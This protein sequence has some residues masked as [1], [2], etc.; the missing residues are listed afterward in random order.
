MIPSLHGHP[1]PSLQ[2][3]G[4]L[5]EEGPDY[6]RTAKGGIELSSSDVWQATAPGGSFT[7]YVDVVVDPASNTSLEGL[8]MSDGAFCTQ[9]EAEGFRKITFY[10]D[11]PDVMA[12]F[13]VTVVAAK[14]G[15]PVLLSN[16]NLVSQQELPGG[17]HE[18]VWEDPFRKPC[19]LFALVAGDLACLED[20]FKTV[21]GR[22]VSLKILVQPHN[23]DKTH[24]AL[25]SLKAAMAWDEKAFG[26]EY[27]LDVFHIV[28]VDNFNMARARAREWPL[29][30]RDPAPFF[31]FFFK[32]PAPISHLF[33][34]QHRRGQWRTR[35]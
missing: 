32:C 33:A 23:L 27:D 14:K 31:L 15:F 7:L 24:Y 4:H 22:E 26:L 18:A 6:V 19:Y 8:Y 10:Q 29:P 2:L 3:N 5:L 12:L 25:D 35:A 17:R 16:G 1:H 9:C 30:H 13:R 21:S 11:R 20:K 34:A 28:A